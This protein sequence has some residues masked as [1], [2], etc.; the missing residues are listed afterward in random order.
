MIAIETRNLSKMYGDQ[1]VVDD[2]S[3][4]INKGE[5]FALLGVNGAGKTTTIKM[6][7]GLVNMTK[8]EAFIFDHN[9]EKAKNEVKKLIAVSP[10]E[11]AI[12]PN[13]TVYENLNLLAGIHGFSKTKR[14]KKLEEIILQFSLEEFRNQRAKTLSG[15]W[16]RRL[17]DRKSVV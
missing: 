7:S 3:L 12:A 14:K 1:L 10:Q 2:V 17:R 9:V 16:K 15:G 5:V 6:L 8:G 4:T 11:T 13:L